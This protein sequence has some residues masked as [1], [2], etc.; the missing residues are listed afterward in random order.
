MNLLQKKW[1][2]HFLKTWLL[3]NQQVKKLI[4][5]LPEGQFMVVDQ[6]SL[7]HHSKEIFDSMK[8]KW[9]LDALQYLPYQQ[10]FKKK[11]QSKV[12]NLEPFIKNK[13][14]I[15]EAAALQSWLQG[16][17]PVFSKLTQDQP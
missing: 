15:D 12:L 9:G 6:A 3:Y 2:E 1:A 11:L 17:V 8:D 7:M 5:T 4:Q 13:G 16:Y 14:L 10:L